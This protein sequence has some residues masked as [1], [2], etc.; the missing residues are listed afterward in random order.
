M[1][2]LLDDDSFNNQ[3]YADLLAKH[4]HSFKSLNWGSFKSQQLRFKILS[5]IGL[6]AG[7]SVL[8]IGCGLADYYLWLSN[9]IPGVDYSG[10]DLSPSMI[11]Q[12]VKRFP[13]L[14]LRSGTIF[15]NPFKELK[16]D[17]VFA[18]GIF[19][20]R[21]ESPESYLFSTIKAMFDHCNKGVAF[22][23]LSTWSSS[24]TPGEFYA[25]PSSVID[26]CRSLTPYVVLRHDYHPCDFTVYIT[27]R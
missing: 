12:A 17:Y 3:V 26:F 9:N 10:I 25:N 23:S 1:N 22:N 7:D 13:E 14:S 18:S 24:Q 27:K 8:D 2:K 11:N 4:G 20:L 19:Y 5:D 15:D 16:F 6:Q 21:K